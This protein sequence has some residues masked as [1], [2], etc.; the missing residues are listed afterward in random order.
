MFPSLPP[1]SGIGLRHTHLPDFIDFLTKKPENIADALSAD[2]IFKDIFWLELHSENFFNPGGPRYRA[3]DKIR[4]YWPISCHGVGLSLGR[5]DGLD[6]EH[7]TK[8]KTLIDW[9]QP[10][11]VSEHLAWSS[12]DQTYLNDLLPLPYTSESLSILCDHIDQTQDFLGRQ[13][14]I[15]NPSSYIR[16][17]DSPLAEADFLKQA[18]Q[19]TGCGLLLDINNVYVS[20]YNHRFD[21]TAYLQ[22]LVGC[23]IQEIHMAGHLDI[24]APAEDET[25]QPQFLLDDHGS[26]VSQP[27]WDLLETGL[28]LFGPKPVLIEWDNN[29]P[30]LSELVDEARKAEILLKSAT[31][32]LETP[33]YAGEVQYG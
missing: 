14:L 30:T 25:D 21:A 19:R 10:A 23:D 7:L 17:K 3:L 6:P 9:V 26:S 20:A 1:R 33:P 22:E 32:H 29:I 11:M 28:S 15:E 13:I 18:S 12:L 31:D 24:P 27:V 5:A 4:D 8:L 16:Y 2:P